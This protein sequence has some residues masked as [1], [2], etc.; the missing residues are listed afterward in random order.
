MKKITFILLIAAT[1]ISAKAQVSMIVSDSM[2]E[3]AYRQALLNDMDSL[4]I[5]R[6]HYED[7]V[8]SKVSSYGV[9]IGEY[10]SMSGFS[11]STEATLFIKNQKKSFEVGL[12]FDNDSKELSGLSFTHKYFILRK[13]FNKNSSIE[14][15]I[16]YNFMYRVT[17]LDKPLT[18][19]PERAEIFGN[20]RSRY[21]SMEHY[22]G[23]GFEI[24][25]L[26]YIYINVSAGFGRYIGSIMKPCNPDP[27]TGYYEGGD[28]W[29]G[30]V[31]LGVGFR[32]Y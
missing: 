5:S 7:S 15:Y 10:K 9:C 6:F 2:K 27:V 23:A 3:E 22:L 16:N 30:V 8:N 24:N 13:K 20:D 19:Y 25:A 18:M 17:Y 32:L 11:A 31:K 26:K 28:G 21:S 29:S 1:I 14:P 4:M 12:F